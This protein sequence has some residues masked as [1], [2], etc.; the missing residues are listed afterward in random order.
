[1]CPSLLGSGGV[2]FSRDCFGSTRKG[3]IIHSFCRFMHSRLKCQLGLRDRS[4]IRTGG[5]G[6]RCGLAVAGAN[7]TAIVGPGRMCLI[8]ISKSN[9]MTGRVGLS[10]SPGA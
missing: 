5:K 2:L 4:A 3:R 10:I 8:L 1:M 7:F 6:L 9:R